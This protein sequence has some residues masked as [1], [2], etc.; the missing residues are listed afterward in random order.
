MVSIMITPVNNLQLIPRTMSE[1]ASPSPSTREVRSIAARQ[2]DVSTDLSPGAIFL[3]GEGLNLSTSTAELTELSM[4]FGLEFTS[5][6]VEHLSVAGYY[7][8]ETDSLNLSWHFTFQKE[9]KVGD[10]T[11]LRT[12]EADLSVSIS[13]VDTRS[14]TP[15][16]HKEDIM[17][18][19]RRLLDD[20]QELA[21]DDNKILGGVVLDYED[22]REIFALD[23]GK[24]AHNLMALIN[25]T[26]LLARLRQM[27]DGSKETVILHPERAKTEGLE[28]TESSMRLENVQLEIRAVTAADSTTGESAEVEPVGGALVPTAPAAEQLQDD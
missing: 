20:I 9:V 21:A 27:L 8:E 28:V 23:D 13:Q 3:S 7:S 25:L 26:I 22:F 12:F 4:S 1:E 24:L 18:L 10:H 15:Y 5:S 2:E 17:S 6:S 16:V 11:K 19:V 14:V